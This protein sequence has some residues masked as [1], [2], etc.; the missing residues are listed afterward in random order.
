MRNPKTYSKNFIVSVP[1]Q[2]PRKITGERFNSL[3]Q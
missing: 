1:F 3:F 2:I